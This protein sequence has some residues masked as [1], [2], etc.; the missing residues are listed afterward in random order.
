MYLQTRNK[1]QKLQANTKSDYELQ[2]TRIKLKIAT[3]TSCRAALGAKKKVGNFKPVLFAFLATGLDPVLRWEPKKSCSRPNHVCW[4]VVGSLSLQT[5]RWQNLLVGS[6]VSD[7]GFLFVVCL[8][9]W[10]FFAVVS[11]LSV[12]LLCG[13]FLCVLS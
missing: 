12:C 1:I 2:T 4:R 10:L 8:G 11:C 13:L 7:G 3:W 5:W 9:F 6:L